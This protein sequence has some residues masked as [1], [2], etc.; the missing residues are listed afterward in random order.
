[1]IE[2]PALLTIK[3]D[4]RR[5]SRQQVDGFRGVQTSF[6]VDALMG[7]GALSSAIRPLG[8]GS[9]LACNAVGPAL[10]AGCGPADILATLAA[11]KF[12][13]PGDIL[14]SAFDGFTGC[15]A[16][17]DRATGMMKNS[18]AAG[19][20]A[21]SGDGLVVEAGVDDL[22]PAARFSGVAFDNH[23]THLRI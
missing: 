18:G 11:L 12:M 20:V 1:M 21:A 3:R 23:L 5:P 22:A 10:T 16:A 7:G 19:F 13:Q 15:A 14:V 2:E 6:V 4:Q 17:G 8:D 9:D